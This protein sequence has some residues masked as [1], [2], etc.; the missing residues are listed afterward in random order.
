MFENLSDRLERSFKILKGEGRI[1]EINVAE[2]LKD[3]RR[4]LLDADV[5][6]K[7][8][9]EFTENVKQKALGQNVLTAV[10][11]HELMVK[12]VHDE[13][14]ALMGGTAAD[15]DITGKPTVILM[16][17][18]QG[19]GKTTFSGKLANMLKSKRGK[20][21]LLVAGDVY[22]PAA[23]EQL[24]I[25]GEQSGV[26]VYFEEE[27]K[28]PVEIAKNA[29]KQAK[30]TGKDLVIIDTAGRLAI[31]EVLMNEITAIKDAVNPNEILFV[32]DAM[33][34]QDAVNTA[35]EFN[36]RLNFDGVVLT[37]L[38]GDTR[39]GAAL[40]IRSV[41][42]KP[43]KFVGT[44]EK[45][46]ALDVFHPERMADRI[47]GMGDIVSLVERAQEQY[48]EDEARRLQKRIAKNQF[49]FNDFIAQIQ[50]VKKMGNLK[51]LASMIPGIGKQ[52]KDLDIDDDAFK[53]IEA[54]IYSMTPAEREKPELLNGSRRA[55]IAKGSGTEVQEVNKLIKQ[56]DET[57][58]M[59]HMMTTGGGKAIMKGVRAGRGGG[60]KKKR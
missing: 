44:G 45:L 48:D 5:N 9:K 46:D 17:G 49:D 19:S 47:L 51:E 41:V 52:I 2:T 15:I 25:L 1:T 31:D 53:S 16:S 59:M 24:K 20:H 39:G 50:Q 23:I 26:P 56:F 4:A 11:P 13:L 34:G 18:L 12:I 28:N 35:K 27:N 36:D 54:I 42:D 3:V 7:T 21:P 58:K 40:S 60:R 43:I 10:K 6:Y 22:R 33:T 8:A 14:A 55:R 30:Q 29:I 38:D 32:V 37:K 57:R